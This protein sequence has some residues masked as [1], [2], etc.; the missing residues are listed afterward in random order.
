MVLFDQPDAFSTGSR[1]YSIF[2]SKGSDFNDSSK[3]SWDNP[4]P[5]ARTVVMTKDE[6]NTPVITARPLSLPLQAP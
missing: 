3:N 2:A 6:R 4:T 1:A 5:Y